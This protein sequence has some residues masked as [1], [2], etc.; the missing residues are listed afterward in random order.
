[1]WGSM[2]CDH[3]STKLLLMGR[4]R[5]ARALLA[6][7]PAGR[8]IYRNASLLAHEQSK[9]VL[10][11]AAQQAKAKP[12]YN[13]TPST[14]TQA[15]DSPISIGKK[16][17]LMSWHYTVQSSLSIYSIKNIHYWGRSDTYL[18]FIF[19]LSHYRKN[20]YALSVNINTLIFL[21]KF[22]AFYVLR[23]KLFYLF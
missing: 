5:T 14:A 23:H 6:L 13:L 3:S 18:A 12:I 9:Y 21:Y 1:M 11:A 22:D 19:V 10:K 17:E 2:F 16:S 15:Y 7:A 4:R 8:W 20:E